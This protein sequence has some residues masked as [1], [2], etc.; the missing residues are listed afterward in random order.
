MEG[1]V[2]YTE[3]QMRLRADAPEGGMP[4]LISQLR[5][6]GSSEARERLVRSALRAT[7]FD[8]LAYGTV[9]ARGPTSF[10]TSY[11]HPGW[12]DVY[13]ANRYHDIDRRHHEAPRSSLPL[14]WSLADLDLAST[15]GPR[16]QRFVDDL[17][18]S[19]I[20]SGLFLHL[21]GPASAD[22]RTVISLQSSQAGRQ[23]IDDQ[24]LG[25]A[26]T[27]ALCLHE[28]ISRHLQRPGAAEAIVAPQACLS[29]LQ[30]EILKCLRRGQSDK[31]IA[32]GLQLSSHA[33]DYHMRQLRRRFAVRNRVQL[34]NAA[35]V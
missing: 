5:A 21:A 32:H 7:G 25:Q 13:F 31:Q 28:F 24:V 8:W 26:L 12:T 20:G 29:A 2:L 6:A 27:L 16:G 10:L 17:R 15:A 33:V 11:A 9:S 1:V 30:Q 4:G 34:A 14:V 19:G 18:A 23:W 22:E 35:A 3:S